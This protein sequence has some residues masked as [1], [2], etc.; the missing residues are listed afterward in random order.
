[1]LNYNEFGNSLP[2]GSICSWLGP[3]VGWGHQASYFLCPSSESPVVTGSHFCRTYFVHGPLQQPADL[4]PVPHIISIQ[5]STLFRIP[6]THM[7]THTRMH[8]RVHTHTHT[9]IAFT[10]VFISTVDFTGLQFRWLGP[11]SPSLEILSFPRSSPFF[12]EGKLNFLWNCSLHQDPAPE[13]MFSD[14]NS[15]LHCILNTVPSRKGILVLLK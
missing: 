2:L 14:P 3:H 11:R 4:L 8:T 6:H 12:N 10:R 7:L 13:P 15:P 5:N 1:M 9:H